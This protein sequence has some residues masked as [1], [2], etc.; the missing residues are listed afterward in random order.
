MPT[1]V[2]RDARS[3]LNL[4]TRARAGNL[5]TGNL[6]EEFGT[7]LVPSATANLSGNKDVVDF[8]TNLGTSLTE[9]GAQNDL[10][11]AQNPYL[12][13]EQ[14]NILKR[15]RGLAAAGGLYGAAV[16]AAYNTGANRFL[17]ANRVSA[18]G[19]LQQQTQDVFNRLGGV[20]GEA[21]DVLGN[22]SGADALGFD[23]GEFRPVLQTLSDLGYGDEVRAV[24]ANRAGKLATTE[25]GDINSEVF[26]ALQQFIMPQLS[27]RDRSIVT[28]EARRMPLRFIQPGESSQGVF[29]QRLAAREG[30]FLAQAL[31]QTRT[32]AGGGLSAI[33]G[34]RLAEFRNSA[35]QFQ[36]QHSLAQGALARGDYRAALNADFSFTNPLFQGLGLQQGPAPA[37]A[38]TVNQS[39]LGAATLAARERFSP[40]LRRPRNVTM[41]SF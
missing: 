18:F 10:L 3:L 8:G 37:A 26:G 19:R 32:N 20:G 4:G 27:G 16:D 7:G 38:R 39:Q 41:R 34:Q 24:L 40:R 15:R 13:Q 25:G 36:L 30:Q 35:E 29:E 33:I 1:S 9:V 12:T 28:Q 2:G 14:S 21:F 22:I 5:N 6:Q 17:A 31:G 23:V 11:Q